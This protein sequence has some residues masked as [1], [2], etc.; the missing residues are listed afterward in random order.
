MVANH[1]WGQQEPQ[2][3]KLQ[4]NQQWGHATQHSVGA[5]SEDVDEEFDYGGVS[6]K[7]VLAY[8]GSQPL[9]RWAADIPRCVR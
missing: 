4:S 9:S 2:S 3:S 6:L 5:G 7:H 8:A 1:H